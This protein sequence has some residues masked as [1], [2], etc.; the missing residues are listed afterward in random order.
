MYACM[1]KYVYVFEPDGSGLARLHASPATCWAAELTAT[2]YFSYF[3]SLFFLFFFIG[4]NY[5]RAR[6]RAGLASGRRP[7]AAI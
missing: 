5:V 3:F 6:R 2:L 7:C 4:G 1:C